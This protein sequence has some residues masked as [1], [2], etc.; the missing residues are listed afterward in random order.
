M[1]Y[2]TIG[3]FAK[4]IAVTTQ[5]LRNWDKTGKLI[6]CRKG[7]TGDRYYSEEQLR[8]VTENQKAYK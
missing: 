2:Y 5:T 4:L 3:K 8:S 7:P 1:Q 6:P